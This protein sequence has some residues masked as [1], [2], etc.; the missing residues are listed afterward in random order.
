MGRSAGQRDCALQNQ[1]CN[2]RDVVSKLHVISQGMFIQFVQ[3]LLRLFHNSFDE[4]DSV[5]A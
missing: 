2:V 4:N 1:F 5:E 3:K